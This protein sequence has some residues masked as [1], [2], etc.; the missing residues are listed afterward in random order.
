MRSPEHELAEDA[1][2]TIK[3]VRESVLWLLRRRLESAAEAQRGM[4][5]KRIE[6]AKEKEKSILYKSGPV[7]G[8]SGSNATNTAETKP[9]Q[10]DY[11]PSSIDGM[12]EPV[13]PIRG[14]DPTVD[15]AAMAD[16]ES[17]L[18][19]E[20]LQLFAQENDTMLK[21]FEDTLSKVQ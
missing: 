4:V 13:M 1:E 3:T 17:Q 19:P 15:R 7:G 18:S 5:E 9:A 14:H 2:K 16:I 6:R 12:G 10:S 8:V 21:H 11:Y 20:Q